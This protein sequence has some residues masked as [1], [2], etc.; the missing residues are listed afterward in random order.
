MLIDERE[1]AI[2]A[3]VCGDDVLFVHATVPCN[4]ALR[5]LPIVSLEM[6]GLA[7]NATLITTV[8]FRYKTEIPARSPQ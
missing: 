4:V 8:K 7:Q 6:I 3:L 5:R 1:N 2:A